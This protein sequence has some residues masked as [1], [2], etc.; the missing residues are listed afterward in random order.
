MY[1]IANNLI[2][3]KDVQHMYM[4]VQY[5]Y[6]MLKLSCAGEGP[7]LFPNGGPSVAAPGGDPVPV[8]LEPHLLPGQAS[9]ERMGKIQRQALSTSVFSTN[10][11][12]L[13]VMSG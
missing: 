10:D 7:P 9:L 11:R 1:T 13:R 6:T 3:A 4:Y 5:K 8:P 12:I 2:P